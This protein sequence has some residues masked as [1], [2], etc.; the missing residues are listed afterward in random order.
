MKLFRSRLSH[1]QPEWKPTGPLFFDFAPEMKGFSK[2]G[3]LKSVHVCAV[4]FVRL[5]ML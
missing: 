3:A 5:L 4:L 2:T 1:D